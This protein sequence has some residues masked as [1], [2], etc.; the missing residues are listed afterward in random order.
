[1]R[2]FD[3]SRRRLRRTA[4]PPRLVGLVTFSFALLGLGAVTYAASL[5]SLIQV[6]Q[7]TEE[8]GFADA[9]VEGLFG[10]GALVGGAS[11][12]AGSDGGA[13]A[14]EAAAD[15]STSSEDGHAGGLTLGGVAFEQVISGVVG[16][17]ASGA[18]SAPSASGSTG[19]GAGPNAPGG[20]H[21][22]A[23]DTTVPAPEPAP[24]VEVPTEPAVT[25]EQERQFYNALSASAGR[26]NGYVGEINGITAAFNN[27]CMADAN[28]R[29]PARHRPQ[30]C[31]TAWSTSTYMC[32]TRSWSQTI[33]GTRR[34]RAISS[35]CIACWQPMPGS[36]TVH[37]NMRAIP[38]PSTRASMPS[39]EPRARSSPNF[40]RCTGG[41]AYERIHPGHDP[42]HHRAAW[43][44]GGRPVP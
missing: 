10:S 6:A 24:P 9:F 42:A 4:L 19:A 33:R 13:Q 21:G 15:G 27:D 8:R 14:G 1:M 28:T 37:G 30:V 20:S 18:S 3:T 17:G 34:R 39:V 22:N 31:E 40:S 16:G 36:F 44:R 25:E 35:G 23:S 26:I 5:P 41:S 12:G 29:V 2:I 43:A 7:R 38:I 11:Q 32:A